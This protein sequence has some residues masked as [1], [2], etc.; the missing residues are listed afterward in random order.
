MRFST[1]SARRGP[2]GSRKSQ[3]GISLM[4]ATVSLVFLVPMVGLMID[5]G[6]LYAV[7]SR[8]QASVDGAALAAARALV[9]GQT[10]AAQ[11]TQAKQNA[12]N[13]FYS[14][15][16]S[17]NWATTNTQMDT[18]SVQVFDDANNSNLRNVTV[19][20]SS[21][22]PTYFMKWFGNNSV[23]V[24]A[25]GN[26]SR[27]DVVAMMV[28]DRSGSMCQGSSTP[29]S[30]NACGAMIQ[31]ANTFISQFAPGRD[32]IGLVS[33]SEGAYVHSAPRTDFNTALPSM[34]NAIRCQGGT[35]T[36]QA[37]ALAYNEIYKIQLPGAL[38]IIVLE[39]DGLPNT[40]N[41]NF[42]DGTSSGVDGGYCTD[43]NGKTYNGGG[44]RTSAS[45]P[46][47]TPGYDMHT[48]GTGTPYMANIPAGAVG[49]LYSADPS[50]GS[51]L[52][53]LLN[54]YQSSGNVGGVYLSTTSGCYFRSQTTTYG[55][56]LAWVQT[57]DVYGNS[58]NPSN[59][60]QAVSVNGNHINLN[61]TSGGSPDWDNIHAA[62]LNATD[63]S[64]YLI[65]TGTYPVNSGV[66]STP[67]P[68]ASTNYGVPG[69][70]VYTI[71]L[72]G[73]GGDQPDYILLQRMANDPNGDLFNGS[74]P[75]YGACSTEPGCI[76][77]SNQ[78]KGMFIFAPSS[79][80][81]AQ[82]WMMIASQILS[83]SH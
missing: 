30:G 20:A 5:V 49:A 40:L 42:W 59:A 2:F 41:Y 37:M 79:S 67:Y 44:W 55:Y 47:W 11:T 19:T 8:L 50:Q 27:R 17:S 52:L 80:V 18:S 60:Y 9:L 65:R 66:S 15:F 39:T 32:R 4:V 10:T 71:G 21:Y 23:L 77:Y 7:R 36:A 81:L 56:D 48:G 76:T 68:P 46:S 16:P 24:Q 54:P 33:F 1:S 28:L 70:F 35:G 14:N 69:A 82:A 13:W 64:A 53:A 22:A 34:I 62:A 72:G 29:C 43:K 74:N 61:N 58:V 25:S 57:K 3:Q 83:L 38:N 75:R 6:V 51:Y 78:P 12:V 26:A 45:M 31:A 73:N 63:N